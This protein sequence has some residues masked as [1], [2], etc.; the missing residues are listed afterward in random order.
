MTYGPSNRALAEM[1][2]VILLG[3]AVAVCAVLATR[4]HTAAAQPALTGELA[5]DLM[6]R[7][8][9]SHEETLTKFRVVTVNG[10]YVRAVINVPEEFTEDMPV[11]I[12]FRYGWYLERIEPVRGKLP[13]P[14]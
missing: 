2:G 1:F 7:A 6:R 4:S 10:P 5:G 3:A 9:A 11:D 13:G 14:G 8:A 12:V